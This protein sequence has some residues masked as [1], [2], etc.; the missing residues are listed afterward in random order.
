[1]SLYRRRFPTI[2]M[3]ASMLVSN[4]TALDIKEI[5]SINVLADSRL[6]PAISELASWYAREKLVSV[7]AD[8]GASIEQ[9]KRIE[10]GEAADLFITTDAQLIEE[11]K[12][13]GQVDVYSIGPVASR[14]DE[15]Y[16]A[17]VIASENMTPARCFLAFLRSPQA[18]GILRSND[19]TPFLEAP[20]PP[21][22]PY[23]A[24][25]CDRP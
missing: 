19:L 24:P 15:Y 16:V 14:G 9:E 2:I 3:T 23:L 18:E 5:Q 6:A 21:Q 20:K 22:P 4:A 12:L 7:S 25:N 13:K 8:F 10:D 1:M 17:A 11:L